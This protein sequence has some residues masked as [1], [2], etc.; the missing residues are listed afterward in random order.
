MRTKFRGNKTRETNTHIHT[1]D[2]ISVNSVNENG[3]R[4]FCA[5]S[6]RGSFLSNKIE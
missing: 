6:E 4:A 3:L 1:H 2:E 5:E